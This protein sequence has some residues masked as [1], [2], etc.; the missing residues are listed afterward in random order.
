MV[1]PVSIILS[2]LT[3]VFAILGPLYAIKGGKWLDDNLKTICE[4]DE[5]FHTN[6]QAGKNLKNAAIG[7][8]VAFSIFVFFFV[9]LCICSCMDKENLVRPFL[10]LLTVSIGFTIGIFIYAIDITFRKI[11][12]LNDTEQKSFCL[13]IKSTH[14]SCLMDYYYNFTDE[15][16]STAFD[17]SILSGDFL[18]FPTIFLIIVFLV[19]FVFLFVECSYD[20][21]LTT[22][23]FDSIIVI[24]SAFVFA[25]FGSSFAFLSGQWLSGIEENMC[26]INENFNKNC[27][28]GKDLKIAGIGGITTISIVAILI[29]METV[30]FWMEKEGLLVRIVSS[31]L[32]ISLGFSIGFLYYAID[33]S[34][35]KKESV[36]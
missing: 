11:S 9:I 10:S 6:Q 3:I 17:H 24:I 32:I 8:L 23:I 31:L 30:L 25:F 7:G 12:D 19:M 5:K 1:E 29:F 20:I 34:Y 22:F 35:R 27:Q 4:T 13:S 16:C 36:I 18:I 15:E 26:Q 2:I 33:I 28:A 14:F 21:C